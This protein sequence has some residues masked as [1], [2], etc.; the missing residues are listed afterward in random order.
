MAS[1][2]SSRYTRDTF[3]LK[4]KAMKYY[5]ENGIPS[6]MEQIL[7][8]MFYDDPSDVHGYL[9]RMKQLY[10]SCGGLTKWLGP[11]TDLLTFVANHNKWLTLTVS[12]IHRNEFEVMK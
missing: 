10:F 11:A 4:Q 9:V 7:N 2:S 6:K 12:L 3:A 5:S 1:A 8:T